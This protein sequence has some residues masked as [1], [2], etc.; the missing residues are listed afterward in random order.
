[1]KRGRKPKPSRLRVLAGN[2][3]HRAIAAEPP[4]APGIPDRPTF[5]DAVARTEWDRIVEELGPAGVLRRVDQMELAGYCL[6]VSRAI[7]TERRA[8]RDAS[9]EPRAEKA[10][11]QVRRFG[12]LFG[13][14]PAEAQRVV[15]KLPVG[16]HVKKYIA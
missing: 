8:R 13:L 1:M 10:W 14:G 5:L 4:I 15:A 7:K 9:Q 6:A 3:G 12:A 11:E 2:P 16:S